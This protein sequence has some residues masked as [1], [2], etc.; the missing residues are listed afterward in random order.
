MLEGDW[1]GDVAVRL[2]CHIHHS[3]QAF[4]E[5]VDGTLEPVHHETQLQRDRSDDKRGARH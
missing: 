2:Y 4:S 1:F 5:E 3:L